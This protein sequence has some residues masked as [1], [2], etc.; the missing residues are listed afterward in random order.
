M[1]GVESAL[2]RVGIAAS[3]ALFASWLRGR[4]PGARPNETIAELLQRRVPESIQRRR[5]QRQIDQIADQV[6]EQ[7]RGFFKS[8]FGG[9][10]ENEVT[11]AALLVG[12]LFDNVQADTDFL[13]A[14]DLDPVKIDNYLRNADASKIADAALSDAGTYVFDQV[15]RETATYVV[16]VFSVM[17]AFST[18]VYREMLRRETAFAAMVEQALSKL[19][20]A[21]KQAEERSAEDRKFETDYRRRIAGRLDRL[22]LFGVTLNEFSRKYALSVA[23]IS[24]AVAKAEP[25][26]NRGAT[27]SNPGKPTINV[28][29]V[30]RI[31]AETGHQRVE[32]VLGYPRQR[33]LIQGEAGSGKTTLLQW[34]SVMAARKEF[35]G[36]LKAWNDRI[37]VYLPLRPYASSDLPRPEQFFNLVLPS[38]AGRMPQTWMHRLLQSGRGLLLLDGL[39]ELP[40]NKRKLFVNWFTDIVTEFPSLTV[41]VTSRPAALDHGT[42][43]AQEMQTFALQPMSLQDTKALIDQWHSA[44]GRDIEDENELRKLVRFRENLKTIMEDRRPIRLLATNPLMCALMCALHRDRHAHLPR[45]RME[46]YRIALE[47]LLERRDKERQVAERD[48][49]NLTYREK[50][51]I[52]QDI[53]YW[54]IRNGQ[55][56]ATSKGAASRISKT[57]T[58]IPGVKQSATQVLSY[59]V[60]RSGVLRSPTEGRIDFLHRSF[61]EFLAAKAAVDGSDMPLLIEKAVDD[62][63]REVVILAAGHA[64]AHEQEV[65]IRE[66]LARARRE[67]KNRHYLYLLAMSCLETSMMISPS[68]R[69]EVEKALRSVVPP[70]NSTDATSIAATGDL[71]IPFLSGHGELDPE[72]VAACVHALAVIGGDHAMRVIKNYAA[73]RR[74]EVAREVI[75]SWSLFPPEEYAHRVLARAPLDRGAIDLID[76]SYIVY[77]GILTRLR[78]IRAEQLDISALHKLSKLSRIRHLNLSRIHF[79]DFSWLTNARLETL[80][81]TNSTIVSWEGLEG[82]PGLRRLYIRGC[83]GAMRASIDGLVGLESVELYGSELRSLRFLQG[84]AKTLKSIS[85]AEC[86]SLASLEGAGLLSALEELRLEDNSGLV[87]LNPIRNLTRLRRVFIRGGFIVD[88][89][90]LASIPSLEYVRLDGGSEYAFADELSN[91]NGLHLVYVK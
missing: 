85:V 42:L 43:Q 90:P 8:E 11:A 51:I 1:A 30:S 84:A 76:S 14:S 27:P 37:P 23:Y 63:W 80:S 20:T 70:K 54:L 44:V 10:P 68:L 56:D 77:L 87:T 66:L 40:E 13:L 38:L 3:Q 18:A 7:L 64:R 81:L 86:P 67:A 46:L 72:V 75:S 69:G 4:T 24:L 79:E 71:A 15:L 74:H 2:L 60:Q 57:L 88:L 78:R 12:D 31:A 65:L 55:S 47:M 83:D 35:T 91:R 32:D 36:G 49:V 82:A 33:V 21:D 73:D 53:A 29:S 16:E 59:L 62:Q 58:H 48:D 52:L 9:V 25:N 45:D 28:S 19:P 22:E 17:P 50:E 5:A 26:G 39:D 34:L 6:S 89:S 41:I 61:Q